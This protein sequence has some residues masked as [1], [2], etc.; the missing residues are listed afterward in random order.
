MTVLDLLP[1]SET[2]F[3]PVRELQ[4]GQ[5]IGYEALLRGPSGKY[6]DP[7]RFL[8][9]AFKEEVLLEVE[10]ILAERAVAIAKK[11][12][13]AKR[14]F[15]NVTPRTFL[16]V[17]TLAEIFGQLP[18][19]QA[20]IELTEAA[21]LQEMERYKEASRRWREELKA[22]VA[23]DDIGV[24]YSRLLAI[25]ELMPRYLKVD[26]DLFRS[27]RR[28]VVL[29]VLVEMAERLGAE[30]IVEGLE[31]AQDTRVALNLGIQLGQ[32]YYLGR[33]GRLAELLAEG[34]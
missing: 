27:S 33:P 8:K 30:I 32:G 25:A 14:L 5:L 20:V 26:S 28:N 31:T 29:P 24:G 21:P 7:V 16:A 23:I 18:K 19:G 22:H 34:G 2:V 6:Q 17:D 1:Q 9:R 13:G 4:T 15:F 11:H 10:R 12:F 3:Q